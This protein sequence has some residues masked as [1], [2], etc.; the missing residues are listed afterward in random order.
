MPM[1]R[2]SRFRGAPCDGPALRVAEPDGRTGRFARPFA[3]PA[4]DFLSCLSRPKWRGSMKDK[5]DVFAPTSFDVS[6]G[7]S[8]PI[9]CFPG[10]MRQAGFQ[11]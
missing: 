1:A 6:Q 11:R 4:G 2:A 10:S 9:T 3:W 8:P 5:K 7:S